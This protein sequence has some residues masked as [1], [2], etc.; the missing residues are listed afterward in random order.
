M[1]LEVHE[2]AYYTLQADWQRKQRREEYFTKSKIGP[3][4]IQILKIFNEFTTTLSNTSV[5]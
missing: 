2:N 5:P 3:Q 1:L 4:S